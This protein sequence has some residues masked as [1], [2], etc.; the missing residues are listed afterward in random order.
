M[1][2]SLDGASDIDVVHFDADDPACSAP[3]ALLKAAQNCTALLSA[4]TA[5]SDLPAGY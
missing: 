2:M 5:R 4:N 3:L 1:L